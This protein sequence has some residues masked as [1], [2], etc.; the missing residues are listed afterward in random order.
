M[1][2]M[3]EVMINRQLKVADEVWIAAALLQREHPDRAD[4]SAKEIADRAEAENITGTLRKGVYVHAL[5]HSVANIPPNPGRYR[6]LFE[7][8]KGR[9]RLFRPGDRY[10]PRREGGKTIPDRTAVPARY[11]TLL[12][13]YHQWAGNAEVRADQ[14][15]ALAGSGR[16]VWA[17]EHAD[18][19]VR[20]LREGWE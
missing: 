3:V 10:D 13:W 9:R 1:G 4:F 18:D 15:L 14:L 12:D 6:M 7:T 11:A 19:Y 17:M 20:R 2:L 16:E 8:A 5:L